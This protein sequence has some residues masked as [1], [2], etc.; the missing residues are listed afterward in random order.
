MQSNDQATDRRD[1]RVEWTFVWQAIWL[2]H[3][4]IAILAWWVLPGGFPWEHPRFWTNQVL[5]WLIAAVAG[6]G[7]VGVWRNKAPAWQSAAVFTATM[8][9]S[10]LIASAV[11]YPI[12]ISRVWLP[13]LVVTALFWTACLAS[14][15]QNWSWRWPVPV[16]LAIG[17]L[18][19]AFVPV[20]E[21]APAPDTTPLDD[22][23]AWPEVSSEFRPA[24]SLVRIGESVTL[25]PPG[26]EVEARFGR[27]TVS[28]RPLLEFESVSPDR[29]WTIFTPP[30]HRPNSRLRLAGTRSGTPG[31]YCYQSS[32]V[33]HL[34]HAEPT[35]GGAGVSVEA[36]NRLAQPVYSHL[37]SFCELTISGHRRISL[38]FS[39][40]E[41]SRI[42]VLPSDY[43]VGRPA[44][45]AYVDAAGVFHVVEAQSA[46]KGPFRTLGQ[47]RL[48]DAPL[49]IRVY[50]EDRAVCRLRID[51]WAR[52]AGR[53]LSPTAGWGVPVNALEFRRLDDRP[54][55]AVWIWMSL[56]SSSVGRGWDSVG[57]APGIYRNRLRIEAAEDGMK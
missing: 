4:I 2:G 5:P 45:F 10:A 44:R 28:V 9:T 47:G 54:T 43:P 15:R 30:S 27:V 24:V 8:W 35:A 12:S 17:V 18:I 21:R 37:N 41:E 38:S 48:G 1:Q 32:F 26:A 11:V 7:I 34:L 39:P 33:E 29:C 19:G 40:C 57:H 22:S 6:V 20:A 13:V 23:V 36:F 46:E 56:S 51:D 42:E 55:A 52:Q 16:S 3:A 25:S 49:R 50:D 14:C 31:W 53:Q